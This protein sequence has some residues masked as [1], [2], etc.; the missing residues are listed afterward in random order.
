MRVEGTRS[1][2]APRSVVWD[3][4]NS[5]EKMAELMPG[6]EGFEVADDTHWSAKVKVPLGLGGLR[7]SINF[8]KTE[9][10]ELEFA[11]LHAKG[12]GVGALMD[13]DTGFHLSDEG[14]GTA[15]RW[16]ADVKIAG[17]VGSMGQRVLQ[18]IVNQQVRNVLDALDKQV[19]EAAAG[20]GGSVE[21]QGAQTPPQASDAAG[22][23]GTPAPT[24]EAA[25]STDPELKDYGPPA[26]GVADPEGS[27]GAEEG[28][29]PLAEEGYSDEPQGP[30]QTA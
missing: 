19:T 15:M 7:M 1:F 30:T 22:D 27:S 25:A 6:V 2:A 14:D 8:E 18:P 4:L 26:E 10:R 3:V 16:E 23:T 13:M 12:T 5:P 11:R 24:T 28:I 9:E 20:G 29:S 17:P 21:A